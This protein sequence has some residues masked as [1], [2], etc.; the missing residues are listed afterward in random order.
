MFIVWPWAGASFLHFVK[1]PF[2]PQMYK[3]QRNSLKVILALKM[4]PIL[5]INV[6]LFS[7]I[8]NQSGFLTTFMG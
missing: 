2:K 7:I 3:A 6:S 5:S 4:V 8:V 1:L